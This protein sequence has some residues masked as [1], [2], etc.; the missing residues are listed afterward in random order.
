M[1]VQVVGLPEWPSFT[2]INRIKPRAACPH[3]EGADTIIAG[4]AVSIDRAQ[5]FEVVVVAGDEERDLSLIEL[6]E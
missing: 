1:L 2:V 5:L 3:D 6:M 4:G